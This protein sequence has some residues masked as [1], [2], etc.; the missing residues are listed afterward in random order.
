MK[1]HWK[2]AGEEWSEPWGT[3]EAQWSE[4]I[5]PRIRDCLPAKIILEIGAG[6]G[7][8]SHFL[9]EH[10]EEIWLVDRVEECV[11]ACRARFATDARVKCFLNDGRSLSI[12]PDAS[13][14]FV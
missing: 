12:L 3:S 9:K 14:D 2:D 5:F 6:F 13:I 4:A 7:R 11:Q 10:C 1:Y 8:W